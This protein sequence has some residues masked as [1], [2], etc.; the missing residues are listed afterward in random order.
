ML[1][2]KHGVSHDYLAYSHLIVF[3]FIVF[4]KNN[5]YLIDETFRILV[6]V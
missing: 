2:T 3:Q 5:I 4:K 6:N 1:S